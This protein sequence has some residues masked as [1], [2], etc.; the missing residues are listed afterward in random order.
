MPVFHSISKL[1]KTNMFWKRGSWVLYNSKCHAE[2]CGGYLQEKQQS[3][4]VVREGTIT[5]PCLGKKRYMQNGHQRFN[6]WLIRN[7]KEDFGHKNL[8]NAG[9]IN[10]AVIIKAL[11]VMHSNLHCTI[12]NSLML[13]HLAISLPPKIRIVMLP[14]LNK[15]CTPL[16]SSCYL[17]PALT[18]ILL[19]PACTRAISVVS[20]AVSH[21]LHINP[22]IGQTA[23]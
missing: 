23:Q 1:T 12:N 17:V 5:Y 21:F 7:V 4:R 22:R 20:L 9:N 11:F 16:V 15:V 14:I 10:A 19:N 13:K 6:H 8:F 3:H 2:C 18:H